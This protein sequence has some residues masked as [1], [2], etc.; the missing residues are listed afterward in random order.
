V[1]GLR[2]VLAGA[3]ALIALQ[4]VVQPEASGR[5]AGIFG[6]AANMARRFLDPAVPALG[7]ASPAASSSTPPAG[8]N[9]PPTTI[10]HTIPDTSRQP[11]ASG[12]GS[13]GGGGGSW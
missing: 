10:P 12:S 8:S 13:A 3:L 7:A 9:P 11:P 5:V 6:L 2:G 4:T 1:R